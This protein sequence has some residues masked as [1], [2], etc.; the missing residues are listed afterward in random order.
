MTE[1][2]M[3][4]QMLDLLKPEYVTPGVMFLVSEDAPTGTVLS[5]GAGVFAVAKIYET[6]GICLKDDGIT[7][8]EVRD[9]WDKICDPAGHEAYEQGGGQTGKFMRKLS[10]G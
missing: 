4:P 10:G 1:N 3:P 5:A 8:E 6:D 2:L 7:A 9:N